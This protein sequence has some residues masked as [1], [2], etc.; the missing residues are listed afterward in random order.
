MVREIYPYSVDKK[1]RGATGLG[2]EMGDGSQRKSGVADTVEEAN[3]CPYY[4][5]IVHL[6]V[7]IHTT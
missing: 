6:C 1:L 7:C 3:Q 5:L 2:E 4:Y